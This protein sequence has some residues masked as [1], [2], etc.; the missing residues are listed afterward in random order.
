MTVNDE[1]A[2][3]DL[4]R[5]MSP[6]QIEKFIPQ[7]KFD[8]L[9]DENPTIGDDNCTICIDF[10]KNGQKLRCVPLCKHIFHSDCL[11]NWLMVTEVCPNCK[12]EI[13]IYTLKAYY[14]SIKQT[15]K[16]KDKKEAKRDD[17][18][19]RPDT[20]GRPAQSVA[21]STTEIV[22]SRL[23]LTPGHNIQ[24]RLHSG[25]GADISRN[26]RSRIEIAD[27]SVK[28]DGIEEY[29]LEDAEASKPSL[30]QA[31]PQQQSPQD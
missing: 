20:R 16:D 14:D 28:D 3:E 1:I 30:S 10:L 24:S 15:R 5:T 11:L 31:P 2:S 21:G 4:I 17:P 19:L 29:K 22:F 8:Q 26:P 6:A 27:N 7:R 12:N 25:T 9:L 18:K 13:S 23:N